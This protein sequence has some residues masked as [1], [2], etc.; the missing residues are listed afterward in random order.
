MFRLSSTPDR[1]S[2]GLSNHRADQSE[3]RGLVELEAF[4]RQKLKQNV[5]DWG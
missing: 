2:G 1:G 5:F 4:K 3:W